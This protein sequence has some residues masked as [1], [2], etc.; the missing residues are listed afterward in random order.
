MS[1]NPAPARMAR[2][3]SSSN[4]APSRIRSSIRMWKYRR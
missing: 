3:V 2:V 4:V 1:V